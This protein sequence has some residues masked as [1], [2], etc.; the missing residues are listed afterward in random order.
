MWNL[1]S[2]NN[3]KDELE[4]LDFDTI[5]Y[6]ILMRS[7]SGVIVLALGPGDKHNTIKCKIIDC[8]GMSCYKDGEILSNCAINMFKK[9]KKPILLKSGQVI[10]NISQED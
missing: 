8:A 5:K 1:N 10:K 9:Y 4:K 3:K 2:W 6:P 7:L